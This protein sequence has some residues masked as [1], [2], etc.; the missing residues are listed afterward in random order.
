MRLENDAIIATKTPDYRCF[1][2]IEVNFLRGRYKA[3]KAGNDQNDAVFVSHDLFGFGDL[4]KLL[5]TG[6]GDEFELPIAKHE[7]LGTRWL[8][9][10]LVLQFF[11]MELKLLETLTFFEQ[12]GFRHSYNRRCRGR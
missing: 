8:G 4:K 12:F 9:L 3:K 2:L 11:G 10:C 7:K 6:R 1:E 5:F